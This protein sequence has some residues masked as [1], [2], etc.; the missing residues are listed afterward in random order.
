[1]GEII[2]TG[3]EVDLNLGAI[4]GVDV[5]QTFTVDCQT[6]TDGARYVVLTPRTQAVDRYTRAVL[7]FG[8]SQP[9]IVLSPGTSEELLRVL[10][11]WLH[12]GKQGWDV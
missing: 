2:Q 10:Q 1:V 11:R 6:T 8:A 3:S 7:G 9:D 4:P 5:L 12:E